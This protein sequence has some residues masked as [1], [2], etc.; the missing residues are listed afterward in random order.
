MELSDFTD[1]DI[2]Y[3]QGES[4]STQRS[5]ESSTAGSTMDSTSYYIILDAGESRQRS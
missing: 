4:R 5:V 3:D 1:E 2:D